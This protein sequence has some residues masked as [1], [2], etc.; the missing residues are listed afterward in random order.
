MPRSF[1]K[2]DAL[3]NAIEEDKSDGSAIR[4]LHQVLFES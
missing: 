3:Q 2:L 4:I 1:Q